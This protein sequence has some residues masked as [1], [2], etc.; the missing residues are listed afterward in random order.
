MS[1]HTSEGRF[2]AFLMREVGGVPTVLI[3]GALAAIF[4]GVGMALAMQ[5]A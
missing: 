3:V 2:A 1:D 4:A 5:F